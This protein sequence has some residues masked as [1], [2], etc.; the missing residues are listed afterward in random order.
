MENIFYWSPEAS[1]VGLYKT[2]KPMMSLDVNPIQEVF[3]KGCP[4]FKRGMVIWNFISQ[5]Q[6]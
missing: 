6:I 5:G 4:Y 2:D 3:K 1:K